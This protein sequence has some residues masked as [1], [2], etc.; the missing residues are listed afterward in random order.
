MCLI[1]GCLN[2]VLSK[3]FCSTHY[4][5]LRRSSITTKCSILNCSSPAIIKGLCNNHYHEQRKNSITVL[6]SAVGCKNMAISKGLCAKHRQQM[7]IFGKIRERTN[8]DKNETK[9]DNNITTM[10]IYNKEGETIAEAFFDSEFEKQII[11][12]K[13]CMSGKENNKYIVTFDSNHH[14]I[15]LHHLIIKLSGQEVP[16]GKIIDHKDRNFLNN[17][18]SNLRFSTQYQNAQNQSKSSKECS[19]KSKGVSWVKNVEK[20]K[21]QIN[22]NGDYIYLG[23]FD[24]E[25]EATKAYNDAALYY[26]GEFAAPNIVKPSPIIDEILQKIFSV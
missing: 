15:Y 18:L 13:W 12:H 1:Q 3:G 23:L 21:A 7:K 8:R 17:L 19:S 4:N 20:W 25:E 6:C 10:L 9:T 26:F 14:I 5:Q 24:T 16:I 11:L 2:K 22:V